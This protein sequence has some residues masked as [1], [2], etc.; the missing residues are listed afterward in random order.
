VRDVAKRRR[1][2]ELYV[3]L[4]E[5]YLGASAGNVTRADFPKLVRAADD[6]AHALDG[7]PVLLVVCAHLPDIYPTDHRLG[8]LSIVGG[9][10][11]YPAVQNV[12]LKARDEGLGTALTTLLCAV[13]PE[14]KSLLAIPDPFVTAA[15]VTL[16][17]PAHAFPRRVKRRPLSE[18]AFVDTFGATLPGVA[19]SSA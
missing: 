13:E 7:I 16:G 5:R 15:M 14:V 2:R 17:W 12:L 19:S 18:I 6:F 9:A 1:L 11:V 8:R 10:S 4:W 3:P